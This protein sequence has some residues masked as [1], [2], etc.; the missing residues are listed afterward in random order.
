MVE[1]AEDEEKEKKDRA[2]EAASSVGEWGPVVDGY[3]VVGG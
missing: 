2:G 1:E 3:V